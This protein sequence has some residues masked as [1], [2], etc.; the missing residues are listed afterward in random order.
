MFLKK[1]CPTCNR[2]LF[3]SD[4]KWGTTRVILF[5]CGHLWQGE[6]LDTNK[7]ID[8]SPST[9][10]KELHPF[11][12][13]GVRAAIESNARILIGD[14]MGLGKTVQAIRTLTSRRKELLPAAL[15]C[16][17]GMKVQWMQEL[18]RWS[19][20]ELSAQPILDSRDKME[21][22]HDVYVFSMDLLSRFNG[23]LKPAFTKA[24]IQTI[25]ID[26]C[27]LIKNHQSKRAVAVR[28][29]CQGIEHILPLS[30]TPI[31]NRAPEFFS[32]WN[33]L[34]PE[35]FPVYERYLGRWVK[36]YY[37]SSGRP[38][39]GGLKNPDEFFDYVKGHYI[40][41]LRE[42]V[43]PELPALN[44]QFHFS[45]LGEKVEAAYQ[46]ELEAFL[47]FYEGGCSTS[48]QGSFTFQ[49]NIMAYL[50]RMR[51]L[52]GLAKI[53]PTADFVDE[54]LMGTDRQITIFCH[55]KDVH[56][57]LLAALKIT[58]ETLGIN[59]PLSL[60]A[61]L[62][63]DS[64]SV[65]QEQFLR[66]E[67][68]VLVASALAFSEGLNLQSCSDCVLV[69]RQWNPANE[70]Q[71]EG[72]FIRMGRANDAPSQVNSTYMI[73]IGTIDEYLTEIVETKREQVKASLGDSTM[74]WGEADIIKSLCEA[75]RGKRKWRI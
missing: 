13:E 50:S 1:I 74:P 25:I 69:E 29:C 34:L 75:L 7:D 12:I 63:A 62:N 73:A 38:K 54:F 11:Q 24:G 64:R 55:H 10:G 17:A 19:G 16:K 40:R 31:K 71:S 45:E 4:S 53:Q 59:L 28:E 46:K 8:T 61:D 49:S 32:I 52:T 33:I 2:G 6:E 3:Q 70:E 21:V 42:D 58:T 60:T 22:G 65:I 20:M 41:R 30:G 36:I 57:L 67:S 44:R 15:F 26:E 14:E 18:L 68:R 51:H 35:K 48:E 9:D 39:Y 47:E 37:D 23:S 27:Q 56:Q 66:G 5:T 43:M 72:R